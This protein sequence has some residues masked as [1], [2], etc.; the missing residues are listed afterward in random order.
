MES[1]FNRQLV[2]SEVKLSSL[3]SSLPSSFKLV[4]GYGNGDDPEPVL[5]T[6][7]I[8]P[9]LLLSDFLSY[10]AA[11]TL[12]LCRGCREKD[13][14]HEEERTTS[15]DSRKINNIVRMTRSV[16]K[17]YGQTEQYEASEAYPPQAWAETSSP[18]GWSEAF[19]SSFSSSGNNAY[20]Q[21]MQRQRSFRSVPYLF[22]T[23]PRFGVERLLSHQTTD[24]HSKRW[25]F[26]TNKHII[27]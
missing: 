4:P 18:D 19:K 2:E 17:G 15:I 13:E 23:G 8:A 14:K 26:R 22:P 6:E 21:Y 9:S 20:I 7:L 5:K 1:G 11:S 27:G 12:V 10:T 16:D 3:S 25:R 24:A